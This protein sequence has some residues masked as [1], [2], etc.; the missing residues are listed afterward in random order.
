MR[1]M[2]P[3]KLTIDAYMLEQKQKRAALVRE[4]TAEVLREMDRQR[5]PRRRRRF[6]LSRFLDWVAFG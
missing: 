2:P 3:G 6:S 5:R 4:V 1:D